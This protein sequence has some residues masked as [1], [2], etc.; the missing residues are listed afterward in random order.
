MGLRARANNFGWSDLQTCDLSGLRRLPDRIHVSDV[1]YLMPT[2][3]VGALKRL[4]MRMQI[5]QRA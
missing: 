1:E 4:P 3:I 5:L 2:G